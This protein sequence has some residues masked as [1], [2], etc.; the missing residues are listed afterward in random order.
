MVPVTASFP[1]LP[2]LKNMG[3]TVNPSILKANFEELTEKIAESSNLFKIGFEKYLR[4]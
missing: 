3:L 4:I 1:I 2:P